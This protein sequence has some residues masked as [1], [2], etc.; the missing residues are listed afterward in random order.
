[1]GSPGVSQHFIGRQAMSY[2]VLERDGGMVQ[3]VVESFGDS[4]WVHRWKRKGVRDSETR[5]ENRSHE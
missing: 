2:R 1:M 4:Y 3:R 5:I